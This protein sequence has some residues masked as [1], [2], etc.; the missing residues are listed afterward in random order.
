MKKF[1]INKQQLGILGGGQLGKMLCQAASRWQLPIHILDKDASFPAAQIATA[2]VSGNFKDYDDVVQFGKTVDVLSI[3]IEHVNTAA[4]HHLKKEGLEIHPA[5]EALDIIKDKGLQKQ[6]Y[7]ERQLPTSDFLLFDTAASIQSAIQK[8][9]LAFPFVQKSRTAGYD[10]QGVA[11]IKE[12]SD[13]PKLMD[14]ASLVEPLV[15]IDKELAVIV[16]RNASGQIVSYPVVEMTF[17]PEANLVDCLVCP[18]RISVDIE[19]QA[20]KLA[21][22]V[23]EAFDICG[24]LA[25]EFFLDKTGQLLINEV[26]PRTHNSGHHTI[27]ACETSQFEQQLRA[28]LNFPL[29]STALRSPAVMVNLLGA[30]GFSGSTIYQGIEDCMAIPGV[31]LHLYGKATTRPFR[32]MGHATILDADLD[33]ALEKAKIIQKTLKIVA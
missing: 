8:E 25:V 30:E 23:M 32:K 16:A 7:K 2:F 26:A 20:T 6:F 14:T 15:D 18:A 4:L 13:L 28:V 11:V 27:E 21:R 24:L 12:E 22:R 5:P 9:Q 10:G 1:E 3:E 19:E 29:G 31:Y 33:K 17:D